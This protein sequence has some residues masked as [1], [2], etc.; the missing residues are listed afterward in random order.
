MRRYLPA[1]AAALAVILT[2]IITQSFVFKAPVP[3]TMATED[4]PRLA[5]IDVSDYNGPDRPMCGSAHRLALIL[6]FAT[7]E[8]GCDE[9]AV[10]PT[11]DLGWLQITPVL[12]RDCNR[13]LGYER[14]TFEDR[15]DRECS[16]Q[17]FRIIQD[18]YNPSWDLSAA[19]R[20]WNPGAGDSYRDKVAKA[21]S[22]ISARCLDKLR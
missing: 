17:M 13:I 18:H 3:E 5:R 10:G 16:E 9:N 19:A 6:A 1:A 21:Y 12:V 20:R 14:Y 7:V 15:L 8:S 4:D 22:D 2:V 11:D